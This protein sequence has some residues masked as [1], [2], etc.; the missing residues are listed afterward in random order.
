VEGIG[1]T[2][3]A[4]L[5]EAVAFPSPEPAAVVDGRA[6]ADCVFAPTERKRVRRCRCAS[7]PAHL[8]VIAE[9]PRSRRS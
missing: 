3:F 9:Q 6:A 4:A 1:E 2:R 7:L 8:F 5:R